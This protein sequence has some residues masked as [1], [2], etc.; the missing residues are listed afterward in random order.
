LS[1]FGRQYAEVEVEL[2]IGMG[3]RLFEKV[4][5]E[6]S[7]IFSKPLQNVC[8]NHPVQ[9][10]RHAQTGEPQAGE[11]TRV[12]SIPPGSTSARLAAT[13]TTHR[14]LEALEPLSPLFQYFQGINR[15]LDC[16]GLTRRAQY[17]PTF[18]PHR[19]PTVFCCP[20]AGNLK[21]KP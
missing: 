12:P 13:V 18:L 7:A 2:E 10:S 14:V 3:P 6:A 16:L 21:G 5:A 9:G 8:A 11:G 20:D 4:A 19:F 15:D 1:R 17:A